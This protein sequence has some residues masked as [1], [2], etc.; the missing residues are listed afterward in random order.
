MIQIFLFLLIAAF[1]QSLEDPI[2]G[3]RA[4]LNEMKICVEMLADS[5]DI[6]MRGEVD[7]IISKFLILSVPVIIIV[8]F[9]ITLIKRRSRRT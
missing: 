9:I 4:F 3:D 7:K 5:G 6:D 8:I 1:A 2:C